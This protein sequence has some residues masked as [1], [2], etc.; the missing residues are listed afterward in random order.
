LDDQTLSSY[1]SN[2]R[3]F[4]ERYENC[5][6]GISE[7]FDVAFPKHCRVLDV[8]AGSGRDLALLLKGGWEAFG[9]EPSVVLI[10]EALRCH[11]ELEG[12][13]TQDGLP[14]LST[15]G[16]QSFEGILCS[17]VLMHIPEEEL[18]DSIFSLRRILK[19]GGRLLVSLPLEPDGTPTCGR[20]PTG[21]FFNG[22]SAGKIEW[23]LS[24][25][26]FRKIGIGQSDDALGRTER[27]WVT[28]LF[29]LEGTGGSRN[30]DRIEAVLNRDRKTATYKL[31]LFRAFAEIAMTHYN[32]A[33]W[34][35]NGKIA[36]P[37][38]LVAE[39]WLGYYWPL[40]ESDRFIP[41]MN[42]E[43]PQPGGKKILFRGSL[44]E[45]ARLSQS[46]GGLSAFL[47]ARNG[48]LLSPD[49]EVQM[50]KALNDIKTAIIK[51]PVVYAQG[52]PGERL[53]DYDARTRCILM[54]AD[55][56]QEFSLMGPWIRETTILRW[57]ELTRDLAR[58]EIGTGEILE[59]LIRDSSPARNV[60]DSRDLFRGMGSLECIWTGDRLGRK[61]WD[62]DHAIPYSLWHNNDLWNLF[63]AASSTN[64]NK[65]DRLPSRRLLEHRGRFIQETWEAVSSRWPARFFHEAKVFG[66]GLDTGAKGW[67]ERL[68]RSFCEAMEITAL[69]RGVER[70][71]PE[72]KNCA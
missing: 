67:P 26:G 16:D 54:G 42:G 7:W 48:K 45:L 52:G 14:G 29:S 38:D 49:T 55:L 62:V 64:R 36:L 40:F 4:A 2:A 58:Q 30:I 51:G 11:P 63:P 10:E 15:M 71:E 18:F 24:R 39:K 44:A 37:V 25:C 27:R 66:E 47:V 20:D 50:K 8:G 12:R 70:W 21:R 61:A 65:S 31:A 34:L 33:R 60:Q 43:S 28:L 72:R 69:Q 57:S 13:L 41:Q 17:A 9:A 59:L 56:W 53:F 46:Q 19:P 5:S 3:E 35:P 6:G 1:D 22:L 68:F 32:W 23:L